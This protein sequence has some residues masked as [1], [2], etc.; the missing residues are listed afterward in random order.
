MKT[1]LLRL[2]IACS[3]TIM[4][5]IP[6]AHGQ[7][8]TG[9]V[10]GQVTDPTGAVVSG[11]H[12][13]A[14]N[15]DTGVDTSTTTNPAG[16]YRIDYLPI[17]NYQLIVTA[18][19]FN[20]ETL[21]GFSLEVLQTANFNIKLKVGSSSTTV[22]VSAAAPI[23]NTSEV[24]LDSTFTANTI[25]NFPLN[26][27][28]F[29]ALTLYVP[30]AVSTAGTG[31]TTS[32]ERSTYYVDTPNIDG[33]RA[34]ANNYTIDGIDMN[35]T[36]NNL[37]SYSPAPAALE[38]I[39]VITADSATDYGNVNGAG[40]VTVLKSGTNQFHGSA[41]GYVQDY[42]LDANSYSN[43]Q[44]LNSSG[45]L[46]PTP[47]S[48]YSQSQFGGTIGGPI[49]HNK[50]FFFGD[51]LGSRYHR[52]GM[53]FASVIP[54]AMRNGDFSVLLNPSIVGTG[55]TIQLYDPLNTAVPFAPYANNQG[56]PIVNPVAKYLSSNPKL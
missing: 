51:Y 11:A 13:V 5:C 18:N 22:S 19:G 34:Q 42:R 53:G 50:L 37:I 8:V 38:E 4:S 32:I 12:V 23:L 36:Y 55:N 47:I 25:E 35:E 27:L 2:A 45:Q 15:L 24:T 6:T 49:L 10:A 17:G 41:Y 56:V 14:H 40:V 29:S 16:L 33:N 39:Q 43:G 28:D 48:P 21:P 54:D 20:T 46:A 52:G 26:G 44:S 31:G 3:L 30:G 1:R 7:S 9:S